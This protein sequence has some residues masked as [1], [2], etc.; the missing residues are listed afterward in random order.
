MRGVPEVNFASVID[1]WNAES[2]SLILLR[3]G[4]SR[5]FFFELWIFEFGMHISVTDW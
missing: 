4:E 2:K 1:F 5:M 3:I